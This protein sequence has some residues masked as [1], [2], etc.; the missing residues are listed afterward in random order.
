MYLTSP[1]C[2]QSEGTLT[3]GT[4][5]LRASLAQ[6]QKPTPFHLSHLICA[7]V[8][9]PHMHR[10]D[11]CTS[12]TAR[13]LAS[14][15]KKLKLRGMRKWHN[16]NNNTN[17]NKSKNIVLYIL[18]LLKSTLCLSLF[19]TVW[20][21]YQHFPHIEYNEILFLFFSFASVRIWIKYKQW[22]TIDSHVTLLWLIYDT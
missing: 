21:I 1:S 12:D 6:T 5:V 3:L 9:L 8:Y 11:Q 7:L 14:V 4:E 15:F 17:N 16:T 22:I 10:A 20:A 19:F 13:H 18:G 2:L